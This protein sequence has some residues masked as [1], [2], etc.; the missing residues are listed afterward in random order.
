M[1]DRSSKLR[2]ERT[3]RKKGAGM[4]EYLLTM[5]KDR[6]ISCKACEVHCKVKNRVPPGAKLGVL[7]TKGPL[8]KGG[9]FEQLNLFMPCYHCN[10]PWCVAACP[11][12]AMTV[13]AKDGIVYI[14]E[15]LCVGCKACIIAC[16]WT[17]PQW[18]EKT[19]KAIK[20]DLCKDRIDQGLKP[21]CV[22]GCTAHA[23]IFAK[24]NEVSAQERRLHGIQSL[25]GSM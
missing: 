17:V 15:E 20:C 2:G 11:T 9:R 7:V 14:Q 5:N 24:P 13:R 12:G 25:M 10:K 21:A 1:W 23:L 8:K 16:P 18:N 19:G 22:T 3:G 6:C 4:S